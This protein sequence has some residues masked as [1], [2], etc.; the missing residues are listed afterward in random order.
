ML[1]RNILLMGIVL[2]AGLSSGQAPLLAA[3]GII[4]SVPDG[5]GSSCHLRFP[6]IQEQTLYWDRPMLKDPRSGDIISYYGPCN[7]DPLGKEQILRQRAQAE[8]TRRRR[9][10]EG[11]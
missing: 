7:Y 4:S 8:E 10:P 1:G 9:V 11:D 6:A 2:T 5:S 3:E